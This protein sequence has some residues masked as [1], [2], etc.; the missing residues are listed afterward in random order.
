MASLPLGLI[1]WLLFRLD[2]VAQLGRARGGWTSLDPRGGC[3]DPLPQLG[4]SVSATPDGFSHRRKQVAQ[5][6]M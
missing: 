4:V 1:R 6:K 5:R 3:P 2:L